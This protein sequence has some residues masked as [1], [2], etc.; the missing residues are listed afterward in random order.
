MKAVINRRLFAQTNLDS[1]ALTILGTIVHR[2]TESGEYQGTVLRNEQ[3][4][5]TFRFIV[6][7][8]CSVM[9][10]DIDLASLNSQQSCDFVVNREGYVV[11][12]VSRGAGGYAVVVRHINTECETRVFDSRELTEGDLFAATLL[13]PGIYRATNVNTCAQGEIV[14]AYPSREALRCPLEPV[15]IECTSNGFIPNRI[16]IQPT[17]GLIYRFEISSRI[18]IDLV[19]PNDG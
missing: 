15:T 11:F 10:L 8:R 17:Q 3:I 2:F 7:E 5:T 16:E 14:V 4:V 9:Q 13:R 18:Q 19:E 12:K 6:D 1:G